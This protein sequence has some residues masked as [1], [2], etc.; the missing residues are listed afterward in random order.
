MRQECARVSAGTGAREGVR[1]TWGERAASGAMLG[2]V[3]S[4]SAMRC[5][6]L[7]VFCDGRFW[8]ELDVKSS[9]GAGLCRFWTRGGCVSE[10]LC[11]RRGTSYQ[12]PSTVLLCNKSTALARTARFLSRSEARPSGSVQG[13]WHGVL[14]CLFFAAFFFPLFLPFVGPSVPSPSDARCDQELVPVRSLGQVGEISQP[15]SREERIALLLSCSLSSA[16]PLRCEISG[17]REPAQ[18]L[19]VGA[20][21]KV[22]IFFLFFPSFFFFFYQDTAM[23]RNETGCS[24]WSGRW[25]P[26]ARGG[27]EKDAALSGRSLAVLELTG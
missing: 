11:A 3:W 4:Q 9:L 2:P 27:E 26:E 25:W 12:V 1:V 24:E 15:K 13:H 18:R 17:R 14:R 16:T 23:R 22:R 8:G 6:S 21:R 20:V 19:E 7:D 5:G 10:P